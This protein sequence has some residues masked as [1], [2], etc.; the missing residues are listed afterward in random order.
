[1]RR[2]SAPVDL[3]SILVPHHEE[4]LHDSSKRVYFA[5]SPS[6][7]VTRRNT[8]PEP[9]KS[10]NLLLPSLSA[11]S[12]SSSPS[13]PETPPNGFLDE[14]NAQDSDSSLSKTSRLQKL[15]LG[16]NL[17]TNRQLPVAVD[18]PSD[19]DSIASIGSLYSLSLFMMP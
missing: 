5:D 18:K 17:K 9:K 19:R 3:A 15:R 14:L 13:R 1:M 4:N 6:S 16:F 10:N 12:R 7:P 11:I 2:V 8:M